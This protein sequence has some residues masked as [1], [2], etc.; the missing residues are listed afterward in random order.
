MGVV[1]AEEEVARFAGMVEAAGGV[2]APL[3]E[4][5]FV[6]AVLNGAR[7]AEEDGDIGGQ[8]DAESGLGAVATDLKDQ[9]R[10]RAHAE[11]ALALAE[12][13]GDQRNRH[14]PRQRDG[15]KGSEPAFA[16]WHG[17]RCSPQLWSRQGRW[18]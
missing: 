14:K 1:A 4:R 7:G 12:K 6:A 9:V 2:H 18:Q 3:E 15:E 5:I 17:R 13:A 16:G 8:S 10:S 11:R